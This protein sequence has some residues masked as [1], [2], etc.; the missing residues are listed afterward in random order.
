MWTLF[1]L[2]SS[3]FPC[4]HVLPFARAIISFWTLVC[5][6][7]LVIPS[8]TG[9]HLRSYSTTKFKR[10]YWSNAG[11]WNLWI[12]RAGQSSVCLSC[13]F[14]AIWVPSPANVVQTV[15]NNKHP[16]SRYIINFTIDLKCLLRVKTLLYK[17]HRY[18]WGLC[19]EEFSNQTT[20][21]A[22]KRPRGRCTNSVFSKEQ[23]QNSETQEGFFFSKIE[24]TWFFCRG[25][26]GLKNLL[27]I[28]VTGFEV[29][30]F[31]HLVTS[32]WQNCD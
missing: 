2:L 32:L 19:S 21:A 23:L 17:P 31:S 4:I 1:I 25:D 29:F 9:V 13:C 12:C 27:N 15:F 7:R 30:S 8:R 28:Q 22:S 6:C 24:N 16:L 26:K 20:E 3:F 5:L 11:L 18:T 14:W 10:A